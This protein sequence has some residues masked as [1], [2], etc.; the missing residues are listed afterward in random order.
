[1][2][3]KCRRL[4]T[5]PRGVSGLLCSG[6][7]IQC[8]MTRGGQGPGTAAWGLC[9][10]ST[11]TPVAGHA[12]SWFP[13]FAGMTALVSSPPFFSV[14]PAAERGSS[15]GSQVPPSCHEAKRRHWSAVFWI[16]HPVRDDGRGPGAGDGCVGPLLCLDAHT[17]R[18]SC[19]VLVSCFRRNDG[20]GVIP[21]VFFRLPRRRAGIQSWLPSAAVLPRGQEASLVCW[22]PHPVRDDGVAL[23]PSCIQCGMTEGALVV[24][25]PGVLLSEGMTGKGI[26]TC[27]GRAQPHRRGASGVLGRFLS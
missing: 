18:W 26:G 20:V 25:R 6:S 17:C 21:G 13:A 12:L 19:F 14:F 4:A 5:R 10:A 22:I 3:P 1:M 8:G 23:D 7:R 16:P 2:A 24:L 15:H 27:R 11:L 9:F